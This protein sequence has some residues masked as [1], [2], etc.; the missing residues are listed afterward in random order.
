MKRPRNVDI[1][2]KRSP[3]LRLLQDGRSAG[4][5]Y[6][7]VCYSAQWPTLYRAQALGYLTDDNKLTAQG[8]EFLSKHQ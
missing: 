3:L 7:W 1:N 2:D 5:D 4:T 8:K 6:V